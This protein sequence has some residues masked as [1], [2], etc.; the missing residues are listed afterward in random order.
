MNVLPGAE[1]HMSGN[2][3]SDL[4]MYGK[5][6]LN[7]REGACCLALT[8]IGKLCVL[9]NQQHF[10]ASSKVPGVASGYRKEVS[11]TARFFEDRQLAQDWIVCS[12]A[13]TMGE[14]LILDSILHHAVLWKLLI[15]IPILRLLLIFPDVIL[16]SP[17]GATAVF[18]PSTCIHMLQTLKLNLAAFGNFTASPRSNVAVTQS[19]RDISPRHTFTTYH[20]DRHQSTLTCY[21]PRH[22]FRSLPVTALPLSDTSP[23]S[24][25]NTIHWNFAQQAFVSLQSASAAPHT[26]H[27][28]RQISLSTRNHT[29]SAILATN[30]K[31]GHQLLRR[32]SFPSPDIPRLVGHP[33]VDT[34]SSTNAQLQTPLFRLPAEL[35]VRIYSLVLATQG[36]HPLVRHPPPHPSHEA[37]SS[38]PVSPLDLNAAV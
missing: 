4:I 11:A 26:T 3:W 17:K 22:F 21:H 34:E 25:S 28:T 13:K 23:S 33:T 10:G 36:R 30:G 32:I 35:R 9:L 37:V 29:S 8:S 15:S 14:R 20:S 7:S 24:I 1:R 12:G 31:M 18:V 5:S 19:N 38:S 16:G 27:Q 6:S 2:C